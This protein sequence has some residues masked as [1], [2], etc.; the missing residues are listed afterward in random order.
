MSSLAAPV[1]QPIEAPA[2]S[3]LG[4]QLHVTTVQRLLAWTDQGLVSLGNFVSTLVIARALAPSEF[5]IYAVVFAAVL[6][7]NSFH[8]AAVIFPLSIRGPALDRTPLRELTVA[9][10]LGTVAL[11][12]VFVGLAYV[13]ILTT[14]RLSLLPYVAATMVF[15]QL[16]ETTRAAFLT[17]FRQRAALPGDVLSYLGQAV[18]LIVLS[19][20]GRLSPETAFLIIAVTSAAAFV[21]QAAQL[22]LPTV[23]KV[24]WREFVSD[25]VTF[26]TWG[27]PARISTLVG[28]QAFPWVLF[29][30]HGPTAAAVFQVL[31]STVAFCNPVMI[32]TSSLVTATI[33]KGRDPHRFAVAR[34]HAFYGWALIAPFLILVAVFPSTAL[35]L[36]YGSQTAYAQHADLLWMMAGAYTC[37]AIV[38][39]ATAVIGGAGRTRSVFL[40]QTAGLA[41][42]VAVGLPLAAYGG[43]RLALIGYLLVQIGRASIALR[44]WTRIASERPQLAGVS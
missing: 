27:V 22:R 37:E 31:S 43:V 34:K 18:L 32:G 15:W 38:I 25:A 3:G 41:I 13:A 42:A 33:A 2:T 11:A 8:A 23:H 14:G 44:T 35:R 12:M 39:Q 10:L 40:V 1:R 7:L 20:R 29:Y 19:R 26:G 21:L 9:A 28:A 30:T 24:R 6:V 16:Q 5:G 17:H 4:L 36:L